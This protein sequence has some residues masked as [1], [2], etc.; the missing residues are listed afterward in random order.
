MSVRK[1]FNKWWVDFRFNRKRYRKPSPDNT[2]DGAKAYET[3]L[4]YK[5]T[6]GEPIDAEE[7]RINFK[8]FAESWFETYVKNNNKHSEIISKESILR[9]HLIPYFGRLAVNN[10][11]SLHVERY[12]TTKLKEG[13]SAKSIN[14]HL[15][16][17]R[18]SLQCAV[19]WDVLKARPVIKQLKTP[20]QKYDF[21]TKEECR[22]LISN[23]EGAWR[24]MIKVVL[25][26]GLRFGELIALTWDDIDF[27]KAEVTVKQAFAKG[28]LGSPKSNKIRYIPMTQF[29]YDT[30]KGMNGKEGY[31]FSDLNSQPLKQIACL[32][33]LHQICKKAG[34]RKIGWHVLRHTFASQLAQRGA[35]LVAIQ[36]LLGHSDIRTTMRYTHINGSVLRDT[37]RILNVSDQYEASEKSGH[38][39]VT[40]PALS[41]KMR[42][43]LEGHNAHILAEE[44]EKR[45]EAL[46]SKP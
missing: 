8:D 22:Q 41:I 26:T 7:K 10:I 35:N 38:N 33:K 3:H 43:V 36:G 15:S 11:G 32:K 5:L 16:V 40:G 42:G 25:G 34:L 44:S 14:N 21:L 20:P 19:E 12:K 17:I 2:R 37:I 6:R 45:A 24:D 27:K 4:R 9:V 31:A 18:K 46:F 29:V 1:R 30:L 13:L 28:V 39:M 23:A